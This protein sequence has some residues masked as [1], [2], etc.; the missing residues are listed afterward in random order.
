VGLAPVHPF[1]ATHEVASALLQINVTLPPLDI[2]NAS[3][4]IVTTG[5]GID[6]A[7]TVTVTDLDVLVPPSPLQVIE[8]IEFE[9][10]FIVS[11]EPEAFFGPDHAP[12]AA[13]D[14]ASLLVHINFDK[15]S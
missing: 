7:P 9:V 8:K 14:V 3:A 2:D 10:S 1:V 6:G 15:P 11:S 12:P 5:F 4:V 13:Q